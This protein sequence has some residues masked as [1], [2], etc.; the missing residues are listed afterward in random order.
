VNLHTGDELSELADA[1]NMMCQHLLESRDAVRKETERRISA[2]EQLRHADRLVSV[3]RLASGIA[4]E[5]GTPLNVISARAKQLRT[6]E[7]PDEDIKNIASVIGNQ[8]DRIARIIRQLLALARPSR[9][10]RKSLDLGKTAYASTTLLKPLA[11]K[12][13]VSLRV[14]VCPDP[15]VVLASEEQLE[16]V[17]TN[18]IVNAIQAMPHGGE[19]AITVS[20]LHACRP[21]DEKSK[22]KTCACVMVSDQGI[23]IAEE[24]ISKVFDPFFTTKDVGE[25]TGLGLSS[26]YEIVHEHGGWIEATSTVGKGSCFSIYLPLANT[27]YIGHEPD[28]VPSSYTKR[29]D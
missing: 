8:S 24:D 23:G 12:R 25:G 17:F 6:S 7:L 14:V 1:L 13:G 22:A 4:H 3:G 2:L 10:E 16:Q 19:V 26:A 15:P 18:L 29:T 27:N 5:V 28:G 21:G 9:N 11:N 20:S